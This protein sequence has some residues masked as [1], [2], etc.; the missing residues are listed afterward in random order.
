MADI[1]NPTQNVTIYDEAGFK[2]EVNVDN[3]L[4]TRDDDANVQLEEIAG[5][6]KDVHHYQEMGEAFYITYNVVLTNKDTQYDTILITNPN[7]SGKDLEIQHIEIAPVTIGGGVYAKLRLY[8]DP[9]ITTNGITL[10][11]Y[12]AQVGNTNTSGVNTF[13]LPTISARGNL[14]SYQASTLLEPYRAEHWLGTG[15]IPNHS[16]LLTTEAT[17]NGTSVQITVK[18]VSYTD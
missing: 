11:Q 16:I 15:L 7:G 14:L 3:E 13:T 2:A 17:S 6:T 5:N 1:P 10:A 18:Y 8:G 12:N 9:T 4:Q